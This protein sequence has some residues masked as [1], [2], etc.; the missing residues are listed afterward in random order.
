MTFFRTTGKDV[1]PPAVVA[2]VI[3]IDSDDMFSPDIKD[4]K[5]SR[6]PFLTI[7]MFF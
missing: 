7:T 5:A 6:R 3:R 1:E 4:D 2:T